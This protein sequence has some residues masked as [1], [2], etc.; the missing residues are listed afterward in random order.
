M[1]PFRSAT[2]RNPSRP[3]A[4][5]LAA[6]IVLSVSV[7]AAARDCAR[8]GPPEGFDG[9]LNALQMPGPPGYGETPGQDTEESVPVLAFEPPLCV[10]DEAGT[11]VEQRIETIQLLDPE[12]KARPGLMGTRVMV[13]GVLEPASTP[14]H[15]TPVVLRVVDVKQIL[16]ETVPGARP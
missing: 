4:L 7:P 6:M 3:A 11:V 16:E 8:I 15:R 12:G 10:A 13:I 1:P 2:P 9:M 5:V 14:A